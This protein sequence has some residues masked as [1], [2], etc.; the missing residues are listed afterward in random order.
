MPEQS[1]LEWLLEGDPAIRWQVMKDLF[2]SSPV[3]IEQERARIALEGW[4]ASLLARQAENGLWGEGLYSPKWTSS[5][6]TL[7]LLRSFGLQPGN[8]QA[9]NGLT[10]LLK[11]WITNGE[12]I[13]LWKTVKHSDICVDAMALALL[14]YFQ[15]ADERIEILLNHILA[16]QMPDGGWN[17]CWH[18]G[19]THSSFHTTLSV[20]E[21]LWEYQ[22]SPLAIQNVEEARRRG[23][24]FLLVHH[25]F[26]SHRTGEIVD[27]RMTKLIFPP[28]WY[29]DFLRALDYFQACGA[30]YD[31]R[32]QDALDLLL[33]KRLPDG[34]WKLEHRY[35]G[36]IF[37]DLERIG[38]PSRWNTLRAL[39]VL[40]WAED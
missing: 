20:L 23:E 38:Q 24:E 1:V 37:F 27:Y 8:P 25:L 39:R 30:A 36:K 35:S 34:R 4:G 9:R 15:Y 31:T 13:N 33:Q 26:R 7:L 29:Y 19:D 32:M 11:G 6:Y 28:R 5:T 40:N 22:K 12:G 3:E 18:R 14:A 17:C 10:L 21:A 2:H 16:H